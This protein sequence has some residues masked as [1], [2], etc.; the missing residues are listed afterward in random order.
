MDDDRVVMIEIMTM[1][2]S[3]QSQSLKLSMLYTHVHGLYALR[4]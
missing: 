1:M 3:P 2:N 4:A